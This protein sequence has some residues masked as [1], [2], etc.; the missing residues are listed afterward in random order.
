MPVYF[1][2]PGNEPFIKIGHADVVSER[3]A[4]LQAGN[5]LMLRVIR[6]IPGGRG[7]E[8]WL[9]HHFKAHRL[10][11]EWFQLVP[12]MLTI[13]VP[14]LHAVLLPLERALE[15]VGSQCAL[16]NAC[17]TAQQTVWH[18][19]RKANGRVPAEYCAAVERATNG[20]VTKEQLRPDVFPDTAAA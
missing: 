12:E 13:D 15:I 10:H 9:H 20:R 5:H 14:S 8:R 18:W 6:E 19:L 16:A 17:G 7:Q 1:L 2:Q 11:R 3:V 4:E